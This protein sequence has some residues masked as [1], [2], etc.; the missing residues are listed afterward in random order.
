MGMTRGEDRLTGD[1]AVA[2]YRQMRQPGTHTLALA[3][4]EL[5]L[6]PEETRLAEKHLQ[7]LGLVT[8]AELDPDATIHVSPEV[9]IVRALTTGRHE[10]DLYRDRIAG[11]HEHLE[12]I[13]AQYLPLGV[14]ARHELEVEVM[15]DLRRVAAY[16]DS[17]TDLTRTE[18][19]S[20]HPGP[21]P[22][23]HLLV[24]GQE[25]NRQL[26]E[27]GLRLRTLYQRRVA[28][29]PYMAEHLRGLHSLGYDIRV[30]H[31][32]PL[33]M[34]IFDGRRA[35]IPIDPDNGRAGA[36]MID[37]EVFVRSLLSV[38]DFCWQNAESHDTIPLDAEDQAPTQ[39]EL[40]ILRMLAAGLK[41]E[42]IARTL[43]VSLRTIS[44]TISDLMQ[45]SG[46]ESRF[47]AGIRA[48]KL[49]WID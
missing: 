31:V 18:L 16:L 32:V 42:K 17:A 27:R 19:V 14:G 30:A 20:M 21:A 15:T 2:L 23:P 9:A 22:S 4:I 1:L 3:A 46:A 7:R 49:G 12:Q 26:A 29:L 48:V 6:T 37:G 35:V 39:Q 13:V 45:R 10:L 36:I 25:R 38:F 40:V 34:L 47:Q 5:G 11:M 8:A 41:D 43:G 33:R 44:R 28:V 24:E